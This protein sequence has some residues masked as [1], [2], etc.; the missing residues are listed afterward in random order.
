YDRFYPSKSEVEAVFSVFAENGVLADSFTRADVEK[1]LVS[2]D[3]VDGL[4]IT[5]PVTY[6]FLEDLF[7]DMTPRLTAVRKAGGAGRDV[8]AIMMFTKDPRIVNDRFPKF[9]DYRVKFILMAIDI[10]R[11]DEWGFKYYWSDHDLTSLFEYEK[12][13]KRRE[14]IY[15]LAKSIKAKCPRVIIPKTATGPFYESFGIESVLL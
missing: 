15:Y 9:D 14:R 10:G 4:T 1:A 13:E 2:Y 11:A 6:A 12:M 8:E 3:E 5:Y 7:D